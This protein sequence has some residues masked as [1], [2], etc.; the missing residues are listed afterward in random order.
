M[1]GRRRRKRRRRKVVCT[2]AHMRG[3]SQRARTGSHTAH[4]S[5]AP[6]LLTH[7]KRPD[8]PWLKTADQ[9]VS[10]PDKTE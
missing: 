6:L 4:H 7:D 10:K 9:N 3:N 1:K 2:S 8:M 5:T